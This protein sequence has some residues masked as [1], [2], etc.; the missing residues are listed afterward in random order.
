MKMVNSCLFTT[1]AFITVVQIGCLSGGVTR[2][3]GKLVEAK[4]YR[5]AIEVYQSIVD[6]KPGTADARAAQLA[7]GELYIAQM[8][9]SEQGIKTYEAIIAEAPASDEAAEAHYRLGIHA[10]RQKDYDAAQTQFDTIVN[11]F[12]HLELSHNALLMLAKSYEEGQK[13]EHAVRV[14]DY[15]AKHYPQ[16]K[17]AAQALANK[18]RIQR[19]FLKDDEKVEKES[20]ELNTSPFGFGTYPEVPADYPFQERLWDN[21]TPGHELLVRVRV[22]L[23]KQGTKT[24]GAMF[25]RNGLIYPT[26]SGVIYVQWHY[27]EEGPPEFAGRRYATRVMGDGETAK[28][29]KS[30]YL[31]EHMFE[32][33]EITPDEIEVSGMKVYEYPNG[34]KVYEYP[35]GGIDPYKFLGLPRY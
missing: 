35:D 10:H 15:F 18:A 1:L 25:D 11:Q 20:S 30:L 5:R 27:V 2:R 33:T 31:A 26:I 24:I 34:T 9:R 8:H 16:S 13:Y 29:W 17:R 14:I 21:A 7:I 28:K 12:P 6:S 32:R 23:W 4:D 3:A 22:K 19:K